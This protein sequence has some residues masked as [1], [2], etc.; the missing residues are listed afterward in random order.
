MSTTQISFVGGGKMYWHVFSEV[1]EN[2]E[3]GK[4]IEIRNLIMQSV[5]TFAVLFFSYQ[6]S[7][8]VSEREKKNATFLF[9]LWKFF[10]C[11][12]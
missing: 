3:G 11:F 6:M 10:I 2:S 12:C 4:E 9:L 5:V 7:L 1:G 8:F